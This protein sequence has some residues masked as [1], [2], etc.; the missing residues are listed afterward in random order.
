MHWGS[1]QKSETPAAPAQQEAR[2]RVGRG[3][4]GTVCSSDI[5]HGKSLSAAAMGLAVSVATDKPGAVKKNTPRYQGT[6]PLAHPPATVPNFSLE[7][8]SAVN[9]SLLSLWPGLEPSFLQKTHSFEDGLIFSTVLPLP[10]DSRLLKLFRNVSV[11]GCCLETH[12][13]AA[14]SLLFHFAHCLFLFP[15]YPHPFS[16]PH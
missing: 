11:P 1:T 16:S 6:Y 5:L 7:L 12:K 4:E 15:P 14:S 2:S 9:F 13:K 10:T 8:C 3:S